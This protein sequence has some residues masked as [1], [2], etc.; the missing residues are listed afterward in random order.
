[1]IRI[2][3]QLCAIKSEFVHATWLHCR[4][5]S[6]NIASSSL[7]CEKMLRKDL[8]RSPVS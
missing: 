7:K 1:M 6:Y 5:E 2:Y 8:V 4:T 3:L